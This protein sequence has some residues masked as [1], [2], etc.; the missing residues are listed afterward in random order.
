MEPHFPILPSLSLAPHQGSIQ[1][2]L[3]SKQHLRTQGRAL[4]PS[5]PLCGAMKTAKKPNWVII[6]LQ[7]ATDELPKMAV[8]RL[9]K[10][11]HTAAG[12]KERPFQVLQRV[13][14]DSSLFGRNYWAFNICNSGSRANLQENEWYYD[15]VKHFRVIWE[16]NGNLWK[17]FLHLQLKPHPRN[18]HM[19]L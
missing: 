16:K 1:L 19:Q 11:S 13:L 8:A 12:S 17:T 7:G 5:L 14:S 4:W 6:F 9:G 15:S 2:R 18:V 3:C 10:Q